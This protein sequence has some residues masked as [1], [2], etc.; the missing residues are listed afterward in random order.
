MIQMIKQILH[1]LKTKLEDQLLL[2]E[3]RMQLNKDLFFYLTVNYILMEKD[4]KQII[5]TPQ[6]MHT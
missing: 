5:V 1:H 6:L 4:L 2:M 3:L